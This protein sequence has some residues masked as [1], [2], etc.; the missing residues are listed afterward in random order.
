MVGGNL[1]KYPGKLTTRTADLTTLKLLWNSV[2]S[3]DDARFAALDVGNFY[4]ETPLERYKYMQL[5]LKHFPQHTIDQ[6]NLRE[7]A[8]NGWVYVEIRKAVIYGLSQAGKLANKQL[9]EHLG[10]AFLL[11][12]GR[13]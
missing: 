2:I 3:T 4:L 5:P 10:P 13:K 1:T 7:N 9:I 11:V 6:Y 12:E 8:K